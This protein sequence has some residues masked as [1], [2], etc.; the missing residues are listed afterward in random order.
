MR[1]L[2]KH[3]LERVEYIARVLDHPCGSDVGMDDGSVELVVDGRDRLRAAAVVRTDDRERRIVV[4]S[5]RRTLTQK[6]WVDTDPEVSVHGSPGLFLTAFVKADFYGKYDLTLDPIARQ[7]L[8][9]CK[10]IPDFDLQLF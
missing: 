7:A 4:V 5:Q 8:N 1:S 9:E 10:I 6:L 3:I 2:A